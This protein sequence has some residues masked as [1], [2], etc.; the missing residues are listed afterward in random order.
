M[1]AIN[2]ETAH[3]PRNT[4]FNASPMQA[5]F[6]DWVQNGRGSAVLIAVAG[7]GKSTTI[8]QSLNY[9]GDNTSV[10]VLAFNASIAKEMKGKIE[11]LGMATGRTMRN[12][13]AKTFHSLGYGAILKKLNKRFNEVETD[14]RKLNR[15]FREEFS[16]E[17][18]DL[19][20][21]F[22]PKL[23]SLGKGEGLGVLRA[24][25]KNAWMDLIRHHDLSLDSED[26]VEAV[27]ID[28]ASQL[29]AL[30]NKVA[31]ERNWIDF[32]DQL[33]LPVLWRLRL[34]QN[35]WVFIDEAQDTNPIRR[36]LAKMVLRP[37]GRLV[38]VGDPNQAIYGFTGAS[39]DAIDLIKREFNAAELPLTV[40]YRCPKVAEALVQ[41]LVPH[42]SVH[43]SAPQGEILRLSMKDGLAKLTARD[44]ILCRNTAPL[45]ELAF[46]LIASGRGCTVLG[47][48]IGTGL[49]NLIKKQ[50][51]KGIESLIQKLEAF[52][53]REVSRFLAAG[54][55]EKAEAI[56]DRVACIT[57]VIFNLPEDMRTVPS[58]ITRLE[59]MFSDD[60]SNLTLCTAH[61]A[62]GREWTNVAILRADLM[63]S[64]WARQQ[65]QYAQEMN[66]IYVA[67]TRF[68]QS[69]IFLG[70]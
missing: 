8:V 41:P 4:G 55:E 20:G 18:K 60:A 68:Q 3:T 11:K 46:Q 65:W 40:S 63:P 25:D 16:T 39:H 64:K 43:E 66:L 17:A 54:E 70:A 61:K 23:V 58:L 31:A 26:A 62:K 50:K 19:Y 49:V 15:L 1:V 29:L 22:V 56:T 53:E 21:S 42:F 9:I 12:V 47:K 45:V 69:L 27:A 37:G 32:D 35:D 5:R 33:Y 44:A 34:W 14:G 2:F 30:S 51:A 13:A 24:D 52:R 57:T 48:D 38:A 7:S 36:A 67:H 28:L 10:T 59:S 6:F